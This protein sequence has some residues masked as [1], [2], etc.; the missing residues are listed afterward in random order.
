MRERFVVLGVAPVRREWFTKVSRL[1]H[2]AAIPVEF[3]KCISTNEVISRLESSRP[4][5]AALIDGSANGID[6]DL[7]DLAASVGCSPIVIDHGLVERDWAE[8]GAK[9]VLPERFEG[10]DLLAVLEDHAQPVGGTTE[11]PTT[12]EAGESLDTRRG[13]VVAVTGSGGMGASTVAMA[14]AQGLAERSDP[15]PLVL[16]DMA[17]RSS[18]AL[19]HDTRDVIPGLTEFVDTHRLGVPNAVEAAASVHSFPERGYDLLLGL[20]HERDWG[21]IPAR[22]LAASWNTLINRYQTTVCDITGD[23]DGVEETGSTDIEDRNR[24]ARMAAR[25]SDLVLTVSKGGAWGMRHLIASIVALEEV[26]VEPSRIVPVINFAPRSPRTRAE[27]TKAVTQLLDG[28]SKEPRAVAP[29]TFI[30]FRKN[31]DA[32]VGSG[33][34]MPSAIHSPVTSSVEIFLERLNADDSGSE[35]AVQQFEEPVAVTPGSLGTW[36]EIDD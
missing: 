21:S 6:R 32:A 16:A 1:A 19:L 27:I 20:R 28:R 11:D 10:A 12:A 3:I 36:S 7:F 24:L 34:P 5:S 15:R 26:G 35:K 18:Q 29:P 2:E 17:L 14:L 31:L 9:A 22:A 33:A 13:R 8:L 25:N 23:F 30:P 4:F